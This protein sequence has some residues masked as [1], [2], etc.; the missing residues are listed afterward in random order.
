MCEYEVKAQESD[1]EKS[2]PAD[3]ATALDRNGFHQS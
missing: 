2:Y 1:A 3:H